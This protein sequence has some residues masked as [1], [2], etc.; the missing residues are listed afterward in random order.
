MAST[1]SGDAESCGGAEG[2]GSASVVTQ[3]IAPITTGIHGLKTK[4]RSLKPKAQHL[5]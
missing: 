1:S 4:T 5:P 3:T 2:R